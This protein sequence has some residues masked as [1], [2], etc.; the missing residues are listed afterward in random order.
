[1]WATPSLS[2]AVGIVAALLAGVP[3]VPLNPRA[4]LRELEHVI[5]DA[6]PDAV[7]SAPGTDLPAALSSVRRFSTPR[8]SRPSRGRASRPF[9]HASS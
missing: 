8:E 4:G 7:L 5:A 2:S 9:R 1:M 3:A 6:A